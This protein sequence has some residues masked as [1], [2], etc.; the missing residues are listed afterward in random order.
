MPQLSYDQTANQTV[1]TFS[2]TQ[3]ISRQIYQGNAGGVLLQTVNTTWA[4]NGTPASHTIILEDNQTQSENETTY[5]SNG[6]LLSLK[7]HDWGIGAPSTVLRTTTLT[8]LSGSSYSSRNI[9]NRVISSQIADSTGTIK[10]REDTAYDGSPLS[11]CPTGVPQHDDTNYGCSFTARG[12]PTSVTTYTNAAAASGAITKNFTYDVFGNPI[13]AQ[14]N[15]CQQKQWTYSS[16]T[17]YAYPDSIVSG[18]SGGPQLVSSVTYNFPTGEVANATDENGHTTSFGY[19]AYG[20]PL[21]ITRPDNSVITYSYNDTAFTSTVSLPI[22]GSAQLVTTRQTDALG[23]A[24]SVT[25]S[26]ASGTKYS[27]TS[28]AYDS[29]GRAYQVSDPNNGGTVYWTTAQYDALGRPTKIILPDS[30]Q[31]QYAYSKNSVTVTDSAGKKR[32][33]QRD[34][35]GR[36]STVIEPDPQNNNQLSL[37]TSVAHSVLDNVMAVTQGVQTRSYVYDDTGRITSFTTVSYTHLTLQTICSV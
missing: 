31:I 14:L 29:W 35:L 34:G 22:Q 15:C 23:R 36:V 21:T 13:T 11:P 12:L 16:V 8:Y 4:G 2:G 30:S 17:Q 37:Q 25:T 7:E 6:N 9:I 24:T 20:R 27:V 10:Y 19:D 18:S 33:I 5:D 28:T 3:E 26:D 1:V 32:Q